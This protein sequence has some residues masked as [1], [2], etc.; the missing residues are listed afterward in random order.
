MLRP[1]F[2]ICAALWPTSAVD[3]TF[4]FL[5][6]EGLRLTKTWDGSFEIEIETTSLRIFV[7]GEEQESGA[8]PLQSIERE[9]HLV[10]TDVFESVSEEGV[11]AFVRTFEELEASQQ[12]VLHMPDEDREVAH[13]AGSVLEG[14]AVRF[15]RETVDEAFESTL[16]D[17]GDDVDEAWLAGLVAETDLQAFAP[18]G[19]A[20]EGDE[21]TVGP[22]A[23]LSLRR[24]GGNVL[25]AFGEGEPEDLLEV[26]NQLDEEL[27]GE[28]VVVHA[29]SV[30]ED[31][32]E[33]VLLEVDGVLEASFTADVEAQDGSDAE[34]AVETEAT[35]EIEAS[36]F[37][38]AAAERF[39]RCSMTVSFA[40]TEDRRQTG[41]VQDMEIEVE[42]TVET[43]A[44]LEI[45]YTI[46]G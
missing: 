42:A 34:V 33:L 24:I 19:S 26:H 2:L 8:Q 17:G 40:Q 16:E 36:L 27:E 15:A 43:N 22:A 3:E 38:D 6:D 31:E 39:V 9:D 5:P 21:W 23:Y 10:W 11:L 46:E 45:E 12:L 29:G 13:D 14:A 1:V 44:E 32:R 28:L 41:R 37:W 25:L 7:G 20:S 30:T 35:L 18:G 4:R